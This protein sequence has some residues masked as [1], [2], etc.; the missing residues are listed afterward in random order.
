M[1]MKQEFLRVLKRYPWRV[2][3][4]LEEY[5]CELGTGPD[6]EIQYWEMV[7]HLLCGLHRDGS[8]DDELDHEDEVV[9]AACSCG[10]RTRF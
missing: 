5:P 2:E 9:W 7:T 6:H 10:H 8:V 3:D 4:Y 1:T